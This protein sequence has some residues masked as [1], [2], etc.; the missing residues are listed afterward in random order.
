M[1]GKMSQPGY[2]HYIHRRKSW[3]CAV[4]DLCYIVETDQPKNI[5]QA[6]RK[7]VNMWGNTR[8]LPPVVI[9]KRVLI[10]LEWYLETRIQ[11][12]VSLIYN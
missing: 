1:S 10:A 6:F 5:L 3:K 11:V 12:I 7:N 4:G 9:D 8:Q 2:L